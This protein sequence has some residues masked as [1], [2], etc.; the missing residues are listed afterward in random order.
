M[1]RRKTLPV[2]QEPFYVQADCCT[3]CGV[4][5]ATAPELFGTDDDNSCVVKKQPANPNEV[6]RMLLTMITAEFGCIRYAG[7]NEEIRRR[8]AEQGEAS[9]CDMLPD[10]SIA[11]ANFD[12]AG[13]KVVTCPHS[14]DA[15]VNDF[16]A[17][18][19][20]RAMQYRVR[21]VSQTSDQCELGVCWYEDAIHSVIV[22]RSN[23]PEWD[24][25][26]VGLPFLV[27][28]WLRARS[29]QIIYGFYTEA[30]WNGARADRRRVPW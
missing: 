8:L 20:K 17:S 19:S 11:R 24:W 4:P 5:D 9:L 15:L 12:H 10:Q 27:E 6:D 25:L 23:A 26:V 22:R 29:K 30:D 16:K 2:V 14:M 21:I 28:D 7:A 1:N 13:I 3:A 18:L